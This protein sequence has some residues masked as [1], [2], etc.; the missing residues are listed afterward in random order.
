MNVEMSQKTSLRAAQKEALEGMS[1]NKVK[2]KGLLSTISQAGEV[3]K[4]RQLRL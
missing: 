3:K 2:R 4:L 1:G